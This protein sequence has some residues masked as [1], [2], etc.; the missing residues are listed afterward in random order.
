MQPCFVPL[1]PC[2]DTLTGQQ[3]SCYF[4]QKQ[5]FACSQKE[6]SCTGC[7][8]REGV[9]RGCDGKGRILG[10][11][12]AI[13]DWWPIKAYRPCPEK[14]RKGETYQRAGQTLEEILGGKDIPTE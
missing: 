4:K 5:L 13:W 7:G 2:K 8:R 3:H 1:L 9:L 6:E 12:G 11:L 10:G 14:Y